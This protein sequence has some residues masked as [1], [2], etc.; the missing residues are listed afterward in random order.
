MLQHQ[1]HDWSA[2]AHRFSK[3]ARIAGQ[4]AP[5]KTGSRYC[6]YKL[7][8]VMSTVSRQEKSFCVTLAAIARGLRCCLSLY[9]HMIIYKLFISKTFAHIFSCGQKFGC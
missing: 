9:Q 5:S 6:Q 8:M 3:L 7:T 2:L 1:W 4:T